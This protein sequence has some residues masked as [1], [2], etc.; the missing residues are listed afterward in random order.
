LELEVGRAVARAAAPGDSD[1]E[2]VAVEL[3]EVEVELAEVEVE[4]AAV[5]VVELAAVEAGQVAVAEMVA[6]E[7]PAAALVVEAADRLLCPTEASLICQS[8]DLGRGHK[9]V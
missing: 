3:A 5:A 4:R 9:E 7:D 6:A 2:A 1:P 8:C